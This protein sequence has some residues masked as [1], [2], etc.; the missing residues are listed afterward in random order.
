M[1][2]AKELV[3]FARSND[4][5]KITGGFMEGK[6]M[7]AADVRSLATLPSREVL[8]AKLTGS[9]KSPIHNLHNVLSGPA[10]KLVYALSAVADSK[11]EAA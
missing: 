1:A 7:E 4:E 8:L 5:L 11:S 2:V 9:L 10:R 3:T 6:V